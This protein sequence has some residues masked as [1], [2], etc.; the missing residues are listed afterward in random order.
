LSKIP[1]N[2]ILLYADDISVTAA[3]PSSH[4]FKINVNEVSVDINE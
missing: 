3:D 2:Q 4:D 1:K